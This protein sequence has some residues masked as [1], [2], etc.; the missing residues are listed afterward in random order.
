MNHNDPWF[1]TQIDRR[2]SDSLK[3]AKYSNNDILPMWVADMDFRSPDAVIEILR[4]RAEHG[5]FGYAVRPEEL[6]TV[7]AD[8]IYRQH[9]WKIQ[10]DWIVWLPGLVCGLNVVCR[11]LTAMDEQIV[12][13][14][15]IYPPFL[16]APDYSERQLIRCPLKHDG[17][18]FQMD[19]DR[20][21]DS[22]TDKTTLLL[23][24]S[25]HNPTG[26]VWDRQELESIVEVCL[27]HNIVICSDE[28]HCD[29]V[30]EESRR[31][32]PTASLSEA[33]ANNTI[34]LMAA[35]KTFNVAGLNC[36]LAVIP[37]PQLRHRFRRATFGIIPHVNAIGYLATLA[38]FEQGHAWH[39]RLIAYLRQNR[40]ML[41]QAIAAT[42]SLKMDTPEAT[43]LGWIDTRPLGLERP[44][45]FFE[46]AGAGLSDGAEFDG[47]G[48]V[49]MNY[50]CTKATLLEAIRRIQKAIG[51]YR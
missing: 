6:N 40:D 3:W 42:G 14:T 37:N 11:S 41:C 51:D 30:L 44:V 35:S 13:F 43:Y 21:A 10:D 49:R 46:Q 48:F 15:P 47:P 26:R 9:G 33:A 17:S 45:E 23:L 27:K 2:Q 29:L 39:K 31:H 19:I 25:P 12:S 8:W 24:C 28:I 4:R 34:T 5:V 50:G 7:V 22:L 38:S 20:F 18:R 16:S 36:A 1:D 32:I